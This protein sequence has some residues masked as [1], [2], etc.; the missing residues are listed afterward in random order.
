MMKYLFPI[1]IVWLAKTYPA[2]LAL[3]WFVSQFIQIFFDIR[4]R[5]LRKKMQEEKEA[6]KKKKRVK[7]A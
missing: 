4:F 7:A 2:G 3:Y 6:G 1:M 5:A